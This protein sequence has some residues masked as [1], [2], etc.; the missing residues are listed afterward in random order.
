MTDRNRNQSSRLDR[1]L[2][3]VE[4]AAH[5]LP[6]QGPIGVFVHHNTLHAFEHLPFEEAVIEASHLFGAEPYMSEAAYRAE[7]AR[8]R[9]Q[10]VDID[11]AL[12]HEPDA[13]VIAR[14]SRGS[15]RRAMITPGVREFDA[16]TIL[17]RTEQGGLASD[18]R[19]P[20]LR[21]LFDA[22][23]ARVIAHEEEPAV[24]RPVDEVIHPW[25]IRL[26]SVFLDQGMAYWPMPHR[27]NGFYKSVRML[28]SR[29]GGIFPQYLAGLDE[30]FQRQKYFSFSATDA[31]LD[32]LDKLCFH[33]ADWEDLL[34]AELL[35][36]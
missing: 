15:L 4:H 32:Y 29:R 14:L 11:A 10:L 8:G 16:A 13:L 27:E 7:L 26:C 21:T 19:R 23:F 22:C 5:L 30:E 35:A 18:L 33:E 36:L 1:L 34:Q 28:L 6:R 31:V 24:P 9:I 17:W 25:L 3:A 12:D 20:A 2:W